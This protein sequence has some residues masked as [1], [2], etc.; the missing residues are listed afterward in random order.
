MVPIQ[1]VRE[2][3]IDACNYLVRQKLVD[4]VLNPIGATATPDGQKKGR[5]IVIDPTD[6]D[7][8]YRGL[9]QY[10]SSYS[11]KIA[12]MWRLKGNE[13]KYDIPDQNLFDIYAEL[14]KRLSSNEYENEL[15]DEGGVLNYVNISNTYKV[16]TAT[17]TLVLEEDYLTEDATE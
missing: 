17:F 6:I 14:V 1:S 15:A 9:G 13:P 12:I 16:L 4:H 2:T 8:E 5:I 7:R 3:L 11:T 10:D